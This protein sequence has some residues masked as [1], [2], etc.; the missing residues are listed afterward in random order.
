MLLFF[1]Y[2][3]F[4]LTFKISKKRLCNLT[5]KWRPD[6]M[7]YPKCSLLSPIVWNSNAQIKW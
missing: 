6:L 3:I 2:K 5:S 4:N 7:V 1:G